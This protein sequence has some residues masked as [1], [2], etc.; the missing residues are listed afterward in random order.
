LIAGRGNVI[1]EGM[2][3]F[4]IGWPESLLIVLFVMGVIVIPLPGRLM[5]R[6]RRR[7]V[8]W[9]GQ[10][11]AAPVET[12]H[13]VAEAFFCSYDSGEYVL[14][15]KQRFRLVFHRGPAVK[16][17][18]EQIVLSLRG[19]EPIYELP[20]T[21]AVLLQPRAGSLLVTLRHEVYSRVE[22]SA[23]RRKRLSKMFD[24]ELDRFREY[25]RAH[26]GEPRQPALETPRPAK[27]IDV[28]RAQ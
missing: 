23:K 21:L 9:T 27:R 3:G 5:R 13:D 4:S 25:L 28:K 12:I 16:D 10:F 14:Q 8:V 26:F 11:V 6:R 17:G 15:D 24:Q 1:M 20:V 2:L 18:D 7:P 22:M 19:E